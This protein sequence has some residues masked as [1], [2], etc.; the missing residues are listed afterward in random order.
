MFIRF[1][2]RLRVALQWHA[3][4]VF[5]RFSPY[6]CPF[7]K[8]LVTLV[9][10]RRDSHSCSLLSH[11]HFPQKAK[12]GPWF[13]WRRL[14]EKQSGVFLSL[15]HVKRVSYRATFFS[16]LCLTSRRF[17]VS[18]IEGML[19]FTSFLYSIS[20]FPVH[21]EGSRLGCARGSG[22]PARSLWLLLHMSPQFITLH[23]GKTRWQ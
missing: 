8:H 19:S 3:R 11:F 4:C 6:W 1:S 22:P 5:F 13:L 14:Q 9:K 15:C 23:H 2:C 18:S 7:A 16:S 20:W 21:V 17:G 12:N 10:V